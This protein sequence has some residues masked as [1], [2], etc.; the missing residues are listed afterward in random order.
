[1]A[2]V[3]RERVLQAARL[4][5]GLTQEETARA[6]R[7]DV[8][9]YR[10][11]ESGAVNDPVKGFSVRRAGRRHLLTRIGEE[12]GIAVEDLVGPDTV[13][14]PEVGPRREILHVLQ[15]AQH[16]VG[17]DA[18]LAMLSRWATESQPRVR[19]LIGVGGAGKSALV[20]RFVDTVPHD[21][22]FGVFVWS[23]YDDR[24]VEA[25][26]G[27]AAKYVTQADPPSAPLESLEILLDAVRGPSPHLFVLDGL[28]VAQSEGHERPRGSIEDALLR[29]FLC[30]VAA[31]DGGTKALL[32]SRYAVVDLAPWQ[33]DGLATS[34]IG[35]LDE[36]AQVDLLRHWGVEGTD[37]LARQHLER[38]GGHALSIATLGSYIAG[39]HGGRLD[40]L[41]AVD[42]EEAAADD[43]LAFRLARLLDDY[44]AAMTPAQRDLLARVA[45][46]PR[47]TDV[48]TLL[49]LA[50]ERGDLAGEIPTTRKAL[51]RGLARLEAMG[52]LYRSREAAAVYAAHP[53]VSGHFRD[54]FGSVAPQ[55]HAAQRERLLARLAAQPS[56]APFASQLGL[57]EELLSHTLLAGRAAD[58]LRLYQRTLGGFAHLGLE[59][60]DMPQGLRILRTFFVDGDPHQPVAYLE[61]WQVLLLLYDLA[62]YASATG[63]PGFA[64][65][66][67]ER[68][69]ALATNDPRQHTTG[70]RTLAYVQR[71]QANNSGALASIERAL[72]IGADSSAHQVRNLALRGAILHDDGQTAAARESFDAATRLDPVRRFRR[73]L[74]EAELLVDVG[75]FEA[76]AALTIPN[77]RACLDRG[78]GGHISHCDVVLGHCCAQQDPERAAA[79]LHEARQWARRSGEIEAQLRC[80]ELALRLGAGP[81]LHTRA[82]AL[83]RGSDFGRFVRRLGQ[84]EPDPATAVRA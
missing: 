71:L 64:V 10:R 6:L 75:S 5:L 60:G 82:L 39:V 1:V 32:T 33:G 80:D 76:A 41:G 14:A 54:K 65:Q 70:L 58:A 57:L 66:C 46:F 42:L 25:L 79:L 7:V 18:E 22:S 15:V 24:R 30:A 47:G 21:A 2:L 45:L 74:W 72:S 44:A 81:Q 11:Y 68:H 73:G 63:D 20:Q 8:R 23:F 84:P 38:F 50:E 16:F 12:L 48:P 19:A 26:L 51:V 78:W 62:L 55:V 83:A 4:E 9:T 56:S 34:Q 40:A 28:E 13:A 53:F 49:A 77:R 31:G 35:A 36:R 29:R 59:H 67:L 3:F 69:E 37:A 52:V 43:L 17:R 61:P 27:A